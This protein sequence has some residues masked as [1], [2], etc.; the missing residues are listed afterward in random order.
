MTWAAI[1]LAGGALFEL[2]CAGSRECSER[3][4]LEH[5]F[6]AGLCILVLAAG[7]AI[8]WS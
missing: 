2:W 5:H 3:Q 8:A 4:R 6:F 1:V 7:A